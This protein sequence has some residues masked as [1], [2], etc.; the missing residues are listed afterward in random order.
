VLPAS[1]KLANCRVFRAIV[2]FTAVRVLQRV[3]E[4]VRG[5]AMNNLTIHRADEKYLTAIV[6]NACRPT[7]ALQ[8]RSDT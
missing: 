7:T 8:I 4:Q 2:E 5:L 3:Q 6:Q 1:R